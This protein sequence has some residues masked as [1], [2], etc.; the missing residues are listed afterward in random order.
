MKR[1]GLKLWS[2]NK[3]YMKTAKELYDKGIYDYIELYALPDSI[4][5]TGMLWRGL[6]IPYIIHAPHYAHG[7]NFS[8]KEKEKSNLDMAGEALRFADLLNAE[9]VIFHP[10]IG[11]CYKETARQMRLIKDA[12]VIVENKPREI[13]V[14]LKNIKENDICA[15]YSPEQIKYIT[16]ETGL[17]FCLD[18]GHGIC[19]ANSLKKD[20][21]SFLKEFI[22][23]NPVMYHISDGDKDGV[24]DKHYNINRGSFDFAEIF[25]LMPDKAVVSVET[26]KSADDNLDDFIEDIRLLREYDE[27][28]GQKDTPCR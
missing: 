12:R 1:F 9:K 10:G 23:L 17:G 6:N 13:A 24:I 4:N 20:V 14:K 22:V 18:I 5:E 25:S 28:Y 2:R 21:I 26:S 16:D 19:A 3:N 15:G 8:D 7:L 27:T 11:G